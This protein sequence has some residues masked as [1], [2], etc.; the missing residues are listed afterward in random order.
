M[1]QKERIIIRK[2][3]AMNA[4]QCMCVFIKYYCYFL[5]VV[6][7]FLKYKLAGLIFFS[8]IFFV[9]FL[10]KKNIYTNI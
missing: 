7:F 5:D 8:K 1:R 3:T 9:F 4:K 10:V 2:T 6:C